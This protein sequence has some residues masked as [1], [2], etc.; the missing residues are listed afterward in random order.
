MSIRYLS[1]LV[2]AV[3]MLIPAFTADNPTVMVTSYHIS[4]EVVTP[5]DAVSITV[6]LA[7]TADQASRT[8]STTTGPGVSGSISESLTT[9]VNA[10]IESAILKTTDFQVVNG[11][12]E[13][14]GEIGPGQSVNLTF[15]LTAP[16]TSG[17][18]FPEAWIRIRD[19]GSVKYPIPV[20]VNS[21]YALSKKP[22]FKITRTLPD[23][24]TPGTS[25]TL[26]VDLTN[27][28]RSK[29]H[30]IT[31]LIETP[32]HSITSLTP[33]QF[34]IREI[35]P[36]D[37]SHLNL[38]FATDTDIPVGII[39]FPL[40]VKFLT[41]DN[42]GYEQKAQIGIRI[43]GK[44]EIGISKYQISPQ[45]IKTGDTFSLIIRLENTGTD[46]A[47]SV[48]AALDIP[49]EGIKEAFVGT[50]EP[51]NDA[52]A[53]F[54]LKATRP[55]EVFYTL[56]VTFQDDYGKHSI[57]EPLSL[58]VQQTNGS[59]VLVPVLILIVAAIAVFLYRRR[60]SP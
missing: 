47:K 39:Q 46:D 38:S 17:V 3:L 50:I 13:D 18:Y 19:S 1:I 26:G 21:P 27:E 52:P 31:V 44:G 7:N 28:G 9:P 29:A 53:V 45:E 57:T 60:S 41:T 42:T 33:E 34:Y 4:P 22:S 59:A 55:G 51:D 15:F 11:W 14:I 24:I 10:Y 25:F 20:N 49:F 30:D 43:Q 5:S 16:G 35:A 54:T 12:Y 37:T 40:T 6:T 23:Q 48:R 36:G 58:S 2:I 8:A 32:E 56:N